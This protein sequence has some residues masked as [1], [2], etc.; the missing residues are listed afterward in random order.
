[1]AT[2]KAKVTVNIDYDKIVNQ[3]KL[4]RAQKQLVNLVRTKADPY[5]PYLSGDLKNTAQENKKSIVYAS[6]HGGTKSYAAINF[7]TNRGMG[8]EG[9]NRG[10]KRG[11][12]WINRMWVNEGDA[13]VNEIAN[14]IGGK[15]SK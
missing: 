4:N 9:L 2:L 3:S 11:K 12:Q 8:R 15:A 10:G 5:V 7:Y 14:T 1:M 13:I 6:Y